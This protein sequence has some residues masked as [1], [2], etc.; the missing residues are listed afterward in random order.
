MTCKSDGNHGCKIEDA[1]MV[2][3]MLLGLYGVGDIENVHI[4][5]KD[6][7]AIRMFLIVKGSEARIM[8]KLEDLDRRMRNLEDR[9]RCRA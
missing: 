5:L 9:S 7:V 4:N 2:E 8:R 3:T 6:P 1:S